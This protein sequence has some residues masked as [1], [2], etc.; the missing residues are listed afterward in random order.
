[1]LRILAAITLL[2][3]IGTSV[4]GVSAASADSWGC[5]YEKCIQSCTKAGGHYCSNYCD[6]ALK[7][8]QTSKICK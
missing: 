3:L 5:S 4:I 6:K 1:M 8:K 7:D 2:T